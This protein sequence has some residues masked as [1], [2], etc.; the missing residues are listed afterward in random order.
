MVNIQYTKIMK[1]TIKFKRLIEKNRKLLIKQH[2]FNKATVWTWIHGKRIPS[3]E[4]AVR[5]SGILD[6]PLADIPFHRI[7][8]TI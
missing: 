1:K 7:E 2:R 6:I 8:R 3:F 4:N 5:L